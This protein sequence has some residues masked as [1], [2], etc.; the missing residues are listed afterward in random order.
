MG[1]SV[2][3]VGLFRSMSE[4]RAMAG[5]PRRVEPG[6]HRPVQPQCP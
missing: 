3:Q 5:R 4:V 6:G 1:I 2:G